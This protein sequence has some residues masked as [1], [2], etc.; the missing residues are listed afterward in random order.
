MDEW[1][2]NGGHS[3]A[4]EEFGSRGA[5]W[6][7][8]LGESLRWKAG[9]AAVGEPVVRDWLELMVP[10]GITGTDDPSGLLCFAV[11]QVCL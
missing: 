11:L 5:G 9:V 4:L 3:K 7:I 8:F 1:R 10:C 6:R 2:T